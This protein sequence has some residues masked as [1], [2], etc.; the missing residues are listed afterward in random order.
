MCGRVYTKSLYDPCVYFHKL[1]SGEYIYLLLYI[2][3][4]LI[5]S[6]NRSPINK[7]KVQ[8]SYK[9]EIKNLEEARRILGMQIKRERVKGR[10]SLTQKAY[11][12][13]VLQ[14]FLIGD[15]TKSV[16]SLLAPHFKRSV[17]MSPKTIDEHEYMFHVSYASAVGSLLY[18]MVC[19]RQDLSQAISMISRY[20]HDPGRGHWKAVIWIFRYIKGTVDVR[21]LF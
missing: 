18:S 10:V 4:M 6:E 19:M 17:R 5:A 11:L 7:L 21:L 3:D 14:K 20:M 2:N 16:S 13:K 12:Q 15:E 1:P 9:F 8:L